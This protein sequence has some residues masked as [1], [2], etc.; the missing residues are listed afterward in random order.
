M[1]DRSLNTLNQEMQKHG[2]YIPEFHTTPDV[3]SLLHQVES[4]ISTN[5]DYTEENFLRSNL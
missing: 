3:H 5:V 2:K 1:N 4:Y